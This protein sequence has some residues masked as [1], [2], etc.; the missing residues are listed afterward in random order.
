MKSITLNG[1]IVVSSVRFPDYY[2]TLKQALPASRH[3]LNIMRLSTALNYLSEWAEGIDKFNKILD[4]YIK[5]DMMFSVFAKIEHNDD[6]AQF[7]INQLELRTSDEN[8]AYGVLKF[9]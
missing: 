5:S 3:S 6:K 1:N 4:W 8:Y 2:Q 7:I 9:G